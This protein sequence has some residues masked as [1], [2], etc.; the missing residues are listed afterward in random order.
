MLLGEENPSPSI[1]RI[2]NVTTTGFDLAQL[3]SNNDTAGGANNEGL[4]TDA[5]V[6]YFAI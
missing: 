6:T 3:E 5:T 4:V 1:L 2:K